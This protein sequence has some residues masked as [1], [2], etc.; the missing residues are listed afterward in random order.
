MDEVLSELKDDSGQFIV[1]PIS[2]ESANLL[3][4]RKGDRFEDSVLGF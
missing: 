3:P 4:S 2:A 1:L